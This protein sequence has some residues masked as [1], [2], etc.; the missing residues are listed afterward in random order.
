MVSR[1]KKTTKIL[2]IVLLALLLIGAFG[3]FYINSSLKPVSNKENDLVEIKIED[4]WYGKKVF[5][6]LE[7]ENVIKNGTIAYYYSRLKKLDLSFK[8]GQYE[9]DRSKSIEEIVAYLSDASNAIQDTVV[10]TLIEGYRLK[11]FAQTISE[12]TK[13]SYDDLI[14]YWTNKDEIKSL[15]ADYP[16]LTE[17]IFNEDVKYTL[18]GYL[19]PDTYEFFRDS[20]PKDITIKMLDNTKL[21]YDKYEQA[22]KNSEYSINQIF[23]LASI[24]QRESGNNNDMKDV[25][26]VFYNRLNVGMQLQSS[27]TVCYALDV[28]L[29]GD[30]TKCEISQSEYDPYNTYQIYGF[31]P[32]PICAISEDALIAALYPNNTEYFFFIG[33]VCGGGETIFAKTYDEQLEN[34]AR[35]LTCY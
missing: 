33:N 25:A 20:S 31:P 26:S 3:A 23:T 22:F 14:S 12:A 16:F 34:Q 10:V 13:L 17:S 15:M 5:N 27:V 9:V 11:D 29:N 28:G 24:V 6:Y 18:E 30:W 21:Y 2:I 32:G 8:A 7:S 35:Y 4:N 1:M 19:F